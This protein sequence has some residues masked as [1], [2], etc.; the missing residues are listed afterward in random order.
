MPGS[1]GVALFAV[2]D[3]F[4][5]IYFATFLEALVLPATPQ[6]Q[7]R[8]VDALRDLA[9]GLAFLGEAFDGDVS[10]RYGLFQDTFF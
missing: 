3:F 5:W 4:L 2:G 9:D 8:R 7:Q 10:L 1:A 6:L